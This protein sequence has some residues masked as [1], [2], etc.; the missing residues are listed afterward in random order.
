MIDWVEL[1]AEF[2]NEHLQWDD[3]YTCGTLS[4]QTL[5]DIRSKTTVYF[6]DEGNISNITIPWHS[7]PS[8]R[9]SIAWK[10]FNPKSKGV[11]TLSI[12][13]SPAK[14]IQGHNVWGSD[15]IMGA[16]DTLIAHFRAAHPELA[17]M[18]DFAQSTLMALDVTYHSYAPN[19]RQAGEFITAL[20]R[21]S[22]GQVKDISSANRNDKQP[23][24]RKELL[25]YVETSA[26]WNP[27]S[28]WYTLKAYLKYNEICHRRNEVLARRDLEALAEFDHIH[29]K[30]LLDFTHAM[31]R[32][33]CRIKRRKLE[34]LGIPTRI[35]QLRTFLAVST[36]TAQSLWQRHFQPIFSAFEGGNMNVT[37]IPENDLYSRFLEMAKKIRRVGK[38]LMIYYG[39]ESELIDSISDGWQ[40]ASRTFKTPDV[41]QVKLYRYTGSD[42]MG[43]RAWETYQSIMAKGWQNITGHGGIKRQ[44]LSDHM[45]IIRAAG[46][47]KATLQQYTGDRKPQIIPFVRFVQVDFHQQQPLFSKAS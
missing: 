26:Y 22:N 38:T 40:I 14:L 28:E 25:K 3:L 37:R 47:S 34:A 46:I 41:E 12:K 33:E 11:A 24:P 10:V 44:T 2:N 42:A 36:I 6:D 4:Q 19:H 45:K 32:W 43:R 15:D 7:V 13:C 30:D 1:S 31:I 29:N 35:D 27:D 9:A 5:F 23:N 8:S 20:K 18:V 39:D 21:I 16:I 17:A